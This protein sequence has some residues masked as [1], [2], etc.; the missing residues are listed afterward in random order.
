MVWTEFFATRTCK[1]MLNHTLKVP[2]FKA[3]LTTAIINKLQSVKTI[4]Y[5]IVNMFL[6]VI[7]FEQTS[8]EPYANAIGKSKIVINSPVTWPSD[9]DVM[10]T[11]ANSTSWVCRALCS[12]LLIR[13]TN[14]F[15]KWMQCHDAPEKFLD[16]YSTKTGFGDC[17]V[18][19]L[20]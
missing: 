2:W 4:A 1:I 18:P 12:A 15:L 16:V 14:N 17:L 20:P 5:L 19:C 3:G 7:Y 9:K 13:W 10:H 8:L 11:T 6:C